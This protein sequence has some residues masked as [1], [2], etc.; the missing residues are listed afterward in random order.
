MEAFWLKQLAI[1][2]SLFPDRLCLMDNHD[3]TWESNRA[4]HC[5]VNLWRRN[6]TF[7]YSYA[8]MYI[9]SCTVRKYLDSL[10]WLKYVRRGSKF[11][12]M[13]F[14]KSILSLTETFLLRTEISCN[15]LLNIKHVSITSGRNLF[16]VVAPIFLIS[17]RRQQPQSAESEYVWVWLRL[18]QFGRAE[19]TH[20]YA[21]TRIPHARTHARTLAEFNVQGDF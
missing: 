2:S 17:P 18:W 1:N 14:G 9:I 4:S 20:R 11:P 8:P 10:T 5:D 6:T 13:T 12:A 21:Y 16:W 19:R 7:M 15:C 3:R